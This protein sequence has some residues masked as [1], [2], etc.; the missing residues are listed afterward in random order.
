MKPIARLLVIPAFAATLA[1]GPMAAAQTPA[2]P[3]A[4]AP[5]ITKIR[6]A[7]YTEQVTGGDQIVT[8]TG[9]ELPAPAG[10][11]YGD[12]VRRPP[13]VTRVGLIRPRLNFVPELLKSVEN[14]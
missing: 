5:A 3:G 8:F 2:K 1:L 12:L 11:M 7:D 4:A 6:T 13:G 9:D 14:L 10:G